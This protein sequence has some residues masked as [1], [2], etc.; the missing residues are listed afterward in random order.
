MN[1]NEN[2]CQDLLFFPE[3]Y[4]FNDF[5]NLWPPI[6]VGDAN[7]EWLWFD[8]FDFRKWLTVI[9]NIF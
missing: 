9:S 3:Y 8:E 6:D 7:V 5:V 1:L 2:N 4:R